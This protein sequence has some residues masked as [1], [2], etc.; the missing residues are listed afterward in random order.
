M[1]DRNEQKVY[2][3]YI[4]EFIEDFPMRKIKVF[5]RIYKSLLVLSIK[6]LSIKV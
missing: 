6:V 5:I 1:Q 4:K 2:S 3:S